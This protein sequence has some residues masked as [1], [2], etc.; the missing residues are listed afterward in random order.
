MEIAI[1]VIGLAGLYLVSNT[2]HR[3]GYSNARQLGAQR[4]R[5]VAMDCQS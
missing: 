5:G 1:P 2:N 3:V 4:G